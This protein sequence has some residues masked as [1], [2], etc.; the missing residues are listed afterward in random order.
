MPVKDA[1]EQALAET[2]ALGA[3]GGL[4]ALGADGAV[5]A[6]FRAGAMPRGVWRAGEQ[7]AVWA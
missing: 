2:A 6:P 7:P 5:A 3:Q 4:I 1:A